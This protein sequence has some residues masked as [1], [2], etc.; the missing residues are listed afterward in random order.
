[1]L[2]LPPLVNWDWLRR[3][4]RRA[5]EAG[6]I[7]RGPLGRGGVCQGWIGV[8]CVLWGALDMVRLMRGS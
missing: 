8:I 7:Q 2:W 1:M 5:H 6:V 4:P 3:Q